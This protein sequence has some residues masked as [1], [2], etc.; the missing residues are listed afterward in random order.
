LEIKKKKFRIGNTISEFDII[1]FY[2]LSGDYNQILPSTE[3]SARQISKEKIISGLFG[4]SSNSGLSK[5]DEF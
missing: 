2:V 4:L 1:K 5:K 3:F